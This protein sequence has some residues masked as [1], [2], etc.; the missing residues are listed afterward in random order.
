[1]LEGLEVSTDKSGQ[2]TKKLR[3]LAQL[4]AKGRTI[5]IILYDQAVS[6]HVYLSTDTN[7]R[8]AHKSRQIRHPTLRPLP[9]PAGPRPGLTHDADGRNPAADGGEPGRGAGGREARSPA[10]DGAGAGG[11]GGE[12]QE[13]AGDEDGQGDQG[14]RLEEGAQ[15][16][17]GGGEE[18]R[19][20][21]EETVG[22]GEEG[23]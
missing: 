10:G 16:D 20:G 4:V 12:E 8:R 22:G 18:G 1:V 23:D 14:G 3:E 7:P 9:E 2:E 11:A 17:G 6:P 21:G 5:H 15:G 19:G 13:A